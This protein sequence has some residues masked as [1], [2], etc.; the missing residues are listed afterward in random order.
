MEKVE[1]LLCPF[2]R[3]KTRVRIRSDTALENFP[4]YCPKCKNEILVNVQKMNISIIEEPDAKTQS[5]I[6]QS[7]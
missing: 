7:R 6:A 1:W 5:H 4:L 3:S 2:C